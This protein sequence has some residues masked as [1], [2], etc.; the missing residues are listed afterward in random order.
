MIGKK[1]SNGW[2]IRGP[3]EGAVRGRKRGKMGG[4]R[5]F[6]GF[7]SWYKVCNRF[8]PNKEGRH[9]ET[10][11]DGGRAGGRGFGLRGRGKRRARTLLHGRQGSLR[12]C[13]GPGRRERERP[14]VDVRHLG[15]MCRP[16][17]QVQPAGRRAHGMERRKRQ[18]GVRRARG[19]GLRG[20]PRGR[21]SGRVSR[22]RF[23][24]RSGVPAAGRMLLHRRPGS[25]GGN[26]VLLR[27]RR[28]GE[29]LF[30]R[31]LP[32][33]D[34]GR[35]AQVR[36]QIHRPVVFPPNLSVERSRVGDPVPSG[37]EGQVLPRRGAG[38]GAG[39]GRGRRLFGGHDALP[40]G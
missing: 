35:T 1:V 40:G 11:M 24:D 5:L 28:T 33:R 18:H 20:V 29:W 14:F 34:G 25:A 19:H 12:D 16:G 31:N 6:S 3:D 39:R 22:G 21:R 4:F 15:R 36:R 27:Y 26:P 30:P 2:K 13:F 23:P 32:F 17:G 37:K 7:P 8:N 38:G 10:D 9:E